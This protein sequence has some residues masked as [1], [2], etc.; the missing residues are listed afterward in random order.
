[1]RHAFS[2]TVLRSSDDTSFL[3]SV[4]ALAP[5]RKAALQRMAAEGFRRE[6]VHLSY[7]ADLRYQGQ[8]FEL[9]LP[10]AQPTRAALAA[11][12]RAFHAAHRRR[13]GHND[14]GQ[15]VQLVALRID[16]AGRSALTRKAIGRAPAA[17]A[18]DA[19]RGAPAAGRVR[20]ILLR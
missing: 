20:I 6:A 4:A 9:S 5:M 10:V 16:V 11:V 7:A 15:P 17:S 12:V 3:A 19:D 18:S 13:Y 14:P 8:S 2:K 1:M